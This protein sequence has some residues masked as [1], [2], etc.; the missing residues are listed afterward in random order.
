MIPLSIFQVDILSGDL[1]LLASL[2]VF[3]AIPVV[4]LG[5]KLGAPSLLL[6]LVLGMLAGP[7]VLGI[8][9]SDLHLAESIG[10]FAMAVI[11]F[12]AG[13]ETSLA[14]TR[15]V[16]RQG[17]M[18]STAGVLL[19]VL[20]TGSAVALTGMPVATCFL[21]AAILSSTDSASV[22]SVLRDKKL[23]LREKLG[24]MLEVESG[25][26]DPVA[27]TLTVILVQYASFGGAILTLFIQLGVGLAIGI[28]VG[29]L[30]RWVLDKVQTATSH[31]RPSL[32]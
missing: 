30:A 7:D 23:R 2:M 31:S 22:F 10:H 14:E 8:H 11:L 26:N 28:A 32:S 17:L 5:R 4:W 18:L 21:L 6:F 16:L 15:P 27:M 9:F 3:V 1:L 13:L 12:T 19:T 24:P 25:S 20:I 29:F